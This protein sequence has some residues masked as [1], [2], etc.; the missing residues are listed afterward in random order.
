ME[1][2]ELKIQGISYSDNTSGAFALILDEINGSK[3]LPIV[4]GGFEAQAIAIA[5]EKKIKTS[6]PLTHELVKGFADKFDIKINHILIH[7]LIDVLFFSNLVC[8]KDDEI[9][10]IDSRTSDAIALSLRF[11][12]PI[13]V[14]KCILDEAG[15]DDNEKYS[16]EINLID[17]SFFKT[18]TSDK[19][20]NDPKDIKKISSNKIKKLL[21]KSIQNEDY[22]MAAKLRDELNIRKSIK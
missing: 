22:E 19:T 3:K 21:E 18:G 2:I 4:I 13:F 6:R 15:F 5:L 10:K 7:K 17:D 14:D 20:I 8:E 9:I 11:D 1:L 12:A 16:E